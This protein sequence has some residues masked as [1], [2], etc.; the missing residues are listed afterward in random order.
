MSQQGCR[1]ADGSGEEH[2]RSVARDRQGD[3]PF[4]PVATSW[5]HSGRVSRW[6][7]VDDDRSDDRSWQMAFLQN[8]IENGAR[9]NGGWAV[10]L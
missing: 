9:S 7:T 1:S 3:R 6:H 10:A 2:L 8:Q 5:L 4:L